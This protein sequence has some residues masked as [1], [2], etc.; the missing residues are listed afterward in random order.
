[1]SSSFLIFFLPLSPPQIELLSCALRRVPAAL[2]YLGR[3][4][5]ASLWRPHLQEIDAAW[6]DFTLESST[7]RCPPLLAWIGLAP[8]SIGE[9]PSFGELYGHGRLRAPQE[10]GHQL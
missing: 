5:A 1:M 2:L 9:V 6:R 7:T 4:W 10:A 3:S 8:S